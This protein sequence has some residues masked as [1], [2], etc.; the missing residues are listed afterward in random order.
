MQPLEQFG[1]RDDW[2][3]S[4]ASN[5]VPRLRQQSQDQLSKSVKDSFWRKRL[6]LGRL[7]G[8][9]NRALGSYNFITAAPEDPNV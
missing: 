1:T 8:A 2:E 3:L 4:D 6:L 7:Y 9:V 5:F